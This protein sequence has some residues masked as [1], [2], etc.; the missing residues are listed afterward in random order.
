MPR[1]HLL[2]CCLGPLGFLLL[3]NT[4]GSPA[5]PAAAPPAA[6]VQPIERIVAERVKLAL[7]D[8]EPARLPVIDDARIGLFGAA[9]GLPIDAV[10]QTR[11]IRDLDVLVKLKLAL[12]IPRKPFRLGGA[13]GVLANIA[14]ATISNYVDARNMRQQLLYYAPSTADNAP[15]DAGEDREGAVQLAGLLTADGC[16]ART[17]ALLR[18]IAAGPGQG[19]LTAAA[20]DARRLLKRF[21]SGAYYPTDGCATP[22]IDPDYLRAVAGAS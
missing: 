18:R 11:S 21:G 3:A 17:I 2:A 19:K 7:P 12:F 4:T 5:P 8:G 10:R 20:V 9:S 1:R 6:A 15:I 13:A 16:G 14:S 22:E